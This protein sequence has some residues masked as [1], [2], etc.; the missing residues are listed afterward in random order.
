M[1][2]T[3][4]SY[5]E[6]IK[7]QS[8]TPQEVVLAYQKKAKSLNPELNACVRFNDEYATTHAE[9]FAQKPLAALPIMVKDNIL[10]KG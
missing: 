4:V 6:G 1:D 3:L 8:F 7:N 2:L 5:L 9:D 10:I